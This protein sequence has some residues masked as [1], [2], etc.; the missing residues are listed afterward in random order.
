MLTPQFTQAHGIQHIGKN[1][2]NESVDAAI[3][4]GCDIHAKNEDGTTLLHSVSC[5]DLPDS[6]KLVPIINL[7]FSFFLV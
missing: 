3:A 1:R 2:I 5:R 7:Y 6:V 4:L